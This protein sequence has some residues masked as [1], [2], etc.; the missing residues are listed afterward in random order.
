MVWNALRETVLNN[1]PVTCIAYKGAF[2]LWA[3]AQRLKGI[4]E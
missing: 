4:L 3:K 1:I 2:K